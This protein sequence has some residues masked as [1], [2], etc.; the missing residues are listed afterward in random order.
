VNLIL[1]S[2]SAYRRELL[3][4]LGM[5]FTAVAPSVDESRLPGEAGSAMAARLAEAKARSVAARHPDCI[6]IGSDQVALCDGEV[7]GK[8]GTHE[9]AVRQLETLSG[10]E[11][12]FHT[13]VCVLQA[14]RGRTGIRVVPYRVKFRPL[15]RAL[16]DRYLVRERPYDCAASAKA[17]ALGIALIER[18]E[19]EDPTA[20][21]GLPLIAVVDL[22][23]EQ[24]V[25]V[26]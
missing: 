12:I 13:A 18:M 20:L 2:T 4:R 15:E 11:V 25:E 5:P 9:N 10:R 23:K 7:F 3:A 21:M 22:L 26:V 24:G 1:A 16:I 8:P 19:G 14:E 17:E 6:V